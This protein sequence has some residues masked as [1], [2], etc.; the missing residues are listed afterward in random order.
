MEL[1]RDK[2]VEEANQ[3]YKKQASLNKRPEGMSSI[4][5][6][7]RGEEDLPFKV[8]G[9]VIGLSTVIGESE[10]DGGMLSQKMCEH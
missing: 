8:K 6:T 4:L 1:F 10:D 2:W 9:E 5:Q 3:S 7:W